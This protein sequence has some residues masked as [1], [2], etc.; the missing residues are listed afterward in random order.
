MNKLSSFWK[1]QTLIDKIL[2]VSLTLVGCIF[3]Y[4]LFSSTQLSQNFDASYMAVF[5]DGIVTK[6]LPYLQN[7][8]SLQTFLPIYF[9][10]TLPPLIVRLFTSNLILVVQFTALFNI[11]ILLISVRYFMITFFKN[12]SY[13]IAWIFILGTFGSYYYAKFMVAEPFYIIITYLSL[14][15]VTLCIKAYE[16]SSFKEY[17]IILPIIFLVNCAEVRLNLFFTGPIIL[18]LSL[19]FIIKNWNVSFD[20]SRKKLRYLITVFAMMLAA[21]IAG[22][23]VYKLMQK[24]IWIQL[25]LADPSTYHQFDTPYAISTQLIPSFLFTMF[26]LTGGKFTQ[27]V[28]PV[29]LSGII[30]LFCFLVGIFL[31]IILPFIFFRKNY[32][33]KN[34]NLLLF[35]FYVISFCLIFYLAAPN[36]MY[37]LSSDFAHFGTR[38]LLPV[39]IYAVILSVSVLYKLLEGKDGKLLVKNLFILLVCITYP[40]VCLGKNTVFY[41]SDEDICDREVISFLNESE[42]TYG[43]GQLYDGYPYQSMLSTTGTEL[44]VFSVVF[45]PTTITPFYGASSRLNLYLDEY[46]GPSFLII[47]REIYNTL[48]VESEFSVYRHMLETCQVISFDSTILFLSETNILKDSGTL[49]LQEGKNQ[50]ILPGISIDATSFESENNRLKLNPN[51]TLTYTLQFPTP[52]KYVISSDFISGSGQIPL[53]IDLYDS[54]GELISNYR[55]DSNTDEISFTISN[56]E[57]KFIINFHLENEAVSSINLSEIIL[58][59]R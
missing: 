7:Y 57:E 35:L 3:L 15:L 14:F 56:K 47:P 12:K 54:K 33:Q 11:S 28:S 44:D 39:L 41:A 21:A 13:L 55:L 24:V 22:M 34:L 50:N 17:I 8:I 30:A 46:S 45:S 25:A 58:S 10:Y 19:F 31:F 23:V 32:K 5:V 18:S 1:K 20:Q 53:Y 16:R 51:Q 6:G 40:I 29:S 9:F 59:M 37:N 52:G 27:G 36:S 48:D 2:Y 42:Y 38:F 49:L 4:F 43:Y 26:S